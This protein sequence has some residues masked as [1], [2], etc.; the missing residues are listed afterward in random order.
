[1]SC[2]MCDLGTGICGEVREG[3]GFRAE[4]YLAKNLTY[5]WEI[6]AANRDENGELVETTVVPVDFCPW[7]GRRLGDE[8]GG[9]E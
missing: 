1:M 3:D 2:E 9:A 5:G 8:G 4:H 6:W 7:C